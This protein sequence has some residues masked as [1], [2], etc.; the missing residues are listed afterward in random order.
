MTRKY[1]K[2][3]IDTASED[4]LRSTMHGTNST[5]N[6]SFLFF[7][8]QLIWFFNKMKTTFFLWVCFIFLLNWNISSASDFEQKGKKANSAYPH[9]LA[10]PKFPTPTRVV[11]SCVFNSAPNYDIDDKV[12]ICY[13]LIGEFILFFSSI[14]RTWS[15]AGLYLRAPAPHLEGSNLGPLSQ[16]D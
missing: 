13:S 9:Q 5:E 15:F 8:R 14:T 2:S 6:Q 1:F 4:C 10:P 7:G 3:S 11:M 12:G 16:Y